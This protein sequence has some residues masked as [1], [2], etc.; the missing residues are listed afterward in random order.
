MLSV[1]NQVFNVTQ[2]MS[3][4]QGGSTTMWIDGM[5]CCYRARFSLQTSTDHDILLRLLLCVY[6]FLVDFLYFFVSYVYI[7]LGE[8]PD[9]NGVVSRSDNKQPAEQE[10]ARALANG[11]FIELLPS[12]AAAVSN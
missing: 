4:D 9:R 6:R 7:Y 11:L 3:M 12:A 1:R 5:C 10:G 8:N 2:A